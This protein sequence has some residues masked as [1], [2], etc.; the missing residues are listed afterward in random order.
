[1]RWALPGVR[2]NLQEGLSLTDTQTITADIAVVGAGMVGAA[3]A[4]GFANNG[5]DVALIEV[6][7]PEFEFCAEHVD[8]RVSAITRASQKLLQKLGV[9]QAVTEMRACPYER[10]HVWDAG[11]EGSIH[12]DA[13]DLGE[14][15]LGYIVENSVIQQAL[16]QKL[17]QHP[18]VQLL[19]PQQVVALARTDGNSRLSLQSGMT[20]QADLVVAADG[21]SS[22]LRDMLEIKTRGWAYDQH[23][24]VATVTTQNGHNSTAWQRFLPDGP[25]AFLPLNTSADKCCSIVWSTSPEKAKAYSEL[26]ADEF[27][28][29]LTQASEGRLG[30]MLEVESRAV[31]PLELR[32]A[33]DYIRE[34]FVLVGDAAHAIHPLAGQGVNLG[35]LDVDALLD[36]VSRARSQSRNPGGLHTLRQ[37]ERCRKGSN[38]VM[39]GAMDMFKRLFSNRLAPLAMLRNRGLSFVDQLGPLKNFFARY[40]MGLE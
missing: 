11:G 20:V 25:L 22:P 10:M 40:A 17:Q 23:A 13:A 36:I 39:L 14:A 35:F 30:Q 34:G 16:W 4:L 12:F 29:E 1:M 27:L 32:H 18:Q 31:F 3:A 8:N 7:P 5:F 15:A 24:L 26:A 6:R 9:W 33:E 19:C 2:A 21:R 37:Y 38:L 28:Q